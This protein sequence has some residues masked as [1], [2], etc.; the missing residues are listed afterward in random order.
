MSFGKIGNWI[1]NKL[2]S[3]GS[4]WKGSTAKK[5]VDDIMDRSKKAAQEIKEKTDDVHSRIRDNIDTNLT[6]IEEQN[7]DASTLKKL[8]ELGKI[9]GI[10]GAAYKKHGTEEVDPDKKVPVQ[11]PLFPEDKPVQ[12]KPQEGGGLKK[13]W[14]FGKNGGL[15]GHMSRKNADKTPEEPQ[16]PPIN[17][18]PVDEEYKQHVDKVLTEAFSPTN[19]KP[20]Q[21]IEGY[22]IA[23]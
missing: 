7:P 11:L 19:I 22:N 21:E 6:N 12:E 23:T 8:V 13:A 10:I 1:D 17:E 2:S 18:R 4:T 20:Y 15:I 9:G 14:E 3:A 16:S 5:T